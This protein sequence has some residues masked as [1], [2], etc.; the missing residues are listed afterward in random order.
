MQK[1]IIPKRS[2]EELEAFYR[3]SGSF[4]GSKSTAPVTPPK[5][6]EKQPE[7]VQEDPI[8]TEEEPMLISSYQAEEDLLVE[9]ESVE[10]PEEEPIA[11]G[12]DDFAFETEAAP[13]SIEEDFALDTN[14]EPLSIDENEDF[15]GLDT[16][17]IPTD[18]GGEED[19]D[20]NFE[21]L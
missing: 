16:D 17:P 1:R 7:P 9:Q 10:L 2:Q 12:G 6:E 8:K 13:D 21:D 18:E 14:E 15:L 11:D 3:K 19:F 4:S 20:L 5:T